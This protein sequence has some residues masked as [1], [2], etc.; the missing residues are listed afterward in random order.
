MSGTSR[1]QRN[2]R[3]AI[4]VPALFFVFGLIAGLCLVGV[5]RMYGMDTVSW[6]QPPEPPRLL[7]KNK[8]EKALPREIALREM[9]NDVKEQKKRL[10]EREKPLTARESNLRLERDSIEALKREIDAAEERIKA[11]TLEVNRDEKGNIKRL[12]KMWAQM[13]PEDVAR[14]V[15]GLD[16]DL[17]ASVMIAMQ[18]KQSAPILAA[19]GGDKMAMDLIKRLKQHKTEQFNPNT[20]ETR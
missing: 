10:D 3:G 19:L 18:E 2:S 11:A 8:V 9:I 17:T 6:L 16:V 13:E 1:N 4:A 12:A 15:R 14:V 5:P 7:P 20:P